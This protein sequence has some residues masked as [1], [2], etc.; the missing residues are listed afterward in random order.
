MGARRHLWRCSRCLGSP[1]Q[2]LAE[3]QVVALL[4]GPNWGPVPV[5]PRAL[6]EPGL[7]SSLTLTPSPLCLAMER[8]ANIL[9]HL[10]DLWMWRHEGT[11]VDMTHDVLRN[12]L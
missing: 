2:L 11:F 10:V 3:L 5:P 1:N 8:E 6:V 4:P 9:Y 7:I 12:K